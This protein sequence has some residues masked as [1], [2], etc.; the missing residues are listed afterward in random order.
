MKVLGFG[1]H[2]F[3]IPEQTKNCPAW[4]SMHGG[5]RLNAVKRACLHLDMNKMP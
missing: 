3:L 5:L 4:Q 1:R 2:H